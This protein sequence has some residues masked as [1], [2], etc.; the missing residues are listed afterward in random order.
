MNTIQAD[1]KTTISKPPITIREEGDQ[2]Q[3]P[4]HQQ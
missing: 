1:L 3:C 4:L 2:H